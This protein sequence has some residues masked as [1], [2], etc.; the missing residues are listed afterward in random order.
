MIN[1]SYYTKIPDVRNRN[2][3]NKFNFKKSEFFPKFRHTD[4]DSKQNRTRPSKDG[5]D[6][7]G[8]LIWSQRQRDRSE[9]QFQL[10]PGKVS[11]TSDKSDGGI[12][13]RKW[14][15]DDGE[16]GKKKM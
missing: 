10:W 1:M 5:L 9:A 15:R 16:Q 8:R 4:D 14:R 7:N 13:R 12:Q 6:R 2:L 3:R 11:V